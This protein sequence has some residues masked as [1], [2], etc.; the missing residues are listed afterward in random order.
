CDAVEFAALARATDAERLER[1]VPLFRDDFLAGLTL[2]DAPDFEDWLAATAEGLRQQLAGALGRLVAHRIDDGDLDAASG[3]ARRWLSLD[4][5]HE[6][7]HQAL[8]RLYAWS[9]QRAAA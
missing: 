8:I 4:G 2:K 6:P 1:A 3:R 9:G 7:A 5:L